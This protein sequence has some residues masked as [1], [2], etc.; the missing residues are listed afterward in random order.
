MSSE[1]NSAFS[2]CDKN[3]KRTELRF[4]SHGHWATN[5]RR[6]VIGTY[7]SKRDSV[8][9]GHGVELR[10]E[11]LR[12]SDHRRDDSLTIY[13]TDARPVDEK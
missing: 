11:P 12:D 2:T 13:F 5:V 3:G 6:T 10:D 1:R 4:Y 9:A 7:L 8:V